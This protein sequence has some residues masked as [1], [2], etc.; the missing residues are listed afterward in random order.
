MATGTGQTT[1]IGMLAVWS[2]LNKV[3]YRSDARSSDVVLVVCPNV[4]IRNRLAE[5]DPLTGE[6]S[7]YRI[8]DVVPPHL[9]ADLMKG[10]VLVMNWHVFEPQGG[11]TGGTAAKV[12]KAG[13][14]VR[15]RETI[16]IGAKTTTARGRRYLTVEDLNRQEAAG[17]LDIIG[18]NQS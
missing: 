1:V 17:L 10:R 2:I 11:L 9:M 16:T 12:T 15:I 3:N 4:T 7:I 8:R 5:L 13:I 14:P 18:F 6:A